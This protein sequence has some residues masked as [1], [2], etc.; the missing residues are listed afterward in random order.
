MNRSHSGHF[1]YDEMF[2]GDGGRPRNPYLFSVFLLTKA[3]VNPVRPSL[4]FAIDLRVLVPEYEIDGGWWRDQHYK[5]SY[6]YRD[7]ITVEATPEKS[8]AGGTAYTVK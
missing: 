1:G 4:G 8:E 3:K 6:L 5:G 2:P 7:S